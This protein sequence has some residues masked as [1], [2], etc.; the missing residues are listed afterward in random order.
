MRCLLRDADVYILT[1]GH[2]PL[3][4]E[5]KWRTPT[6]EVEH[7]QASTNRTF[8]AHFQRD[9]S[10]A[11]AVLLDVPFKPLHLG[12][13]ADGDFLIAGSDKVA[14]EPRAA[15]VDPDGQFQRFVELKGDVHLRNES[16]ASRKNQD[17]TA[18]PRFAPG[19]RLGTSLREVLFTSQIVGGWL[20]SSSVPPG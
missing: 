9:G 2:I 5:T 17:P 6:G 12:V 20:E 13:F 4:Y 7:H 15:I 10:Y 19:E 14:D 18:L 8:V 1:P 3:G 11:G 16:D